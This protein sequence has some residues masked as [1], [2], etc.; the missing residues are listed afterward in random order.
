[1]ANRERANRLHEEGAAVMWD[2]GD[3]GL[4]KFLAAVELAPEKAESWYNMGLIHKYRGAWT[5]SFECNKKAHQ[6]SPDDDA[7]RWNLAIAATA[8][9]K[10]KEAREVWGLV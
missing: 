1:M 2:D 9:N 6:Y 7:T 4:S 10:W 5:E 3:A 8:L